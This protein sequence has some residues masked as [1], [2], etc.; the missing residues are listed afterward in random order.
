LGD[1]CGFANANRL[2]AGDVWIKSTG[3]AGFVEFENFL[4]VI[5]YLVRSW[6]GRLIDVDDGA[7]EAFLDGAF[8]WW[9]AKGCFGLMFDEELFVHNVN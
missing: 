6:T 2:N 7:G 4:D 3:V 9:F 5:R 1:S 8:F